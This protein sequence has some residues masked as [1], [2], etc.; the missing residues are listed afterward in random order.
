M[1]KINII[2]G[3][4]LIILGILVLNIPTGCQNNSRKNTHIPD[5]GERIVYSDTQYQMT[6]GVA[7]HKSS[8]VSGREYV[9]IPLTLKNGSGTSII[10][11]TRVCVTAYA[12]PSGENCPH[13]HEAV[14]FGKEHISG[15][16]LFDGI[17]Y[18]GRETSGWLAFDLPEDTRSV[19]VDFSTGIND[20]QC[21][22]FDCEI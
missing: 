19:H 7:I 12:L 16:R 2:R 17:I 21:L 8:P 18:S 15:F 4:A 3:I 11:S 6:Q 14:M 5:E 10:F 22:S 20:E 13:S 9:F 1:K